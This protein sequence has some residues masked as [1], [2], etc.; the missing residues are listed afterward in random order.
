MLILNFEHAHLTK[1]IPNGGI[2]QNV[3]VVVDKV[4]GAGYQPIRISDGEDKLVDLYLTKEQV[5][6]LIRALK[7]AIGHDGVIL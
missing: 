4:T 7:E 2:A 6:M 1:D 5:M 3:R